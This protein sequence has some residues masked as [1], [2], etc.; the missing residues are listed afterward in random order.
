MEE[1]LTNYNIDD[2][3]VYELI[4]MNLDSAKVGSYGYSVHN[5]RDFVKESSLLSFGR[6]KKVY[7][8]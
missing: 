3:V 7:Q 5:R 2:A 6:A 8:F 1:Y 4:H